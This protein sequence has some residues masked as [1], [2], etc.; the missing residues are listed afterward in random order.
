MV[1]LRADGSLLGD[2]YAFATTAS[3]A[4]MMVIA[5]RHRVIPMLPAACMSALLS[6]LVA[7]PFV[8]WVMPVGVDLLNLALFGLVKSAL[9]LALFTIGSRMI[10]AAETALIGAL[11]APL[12][13]VSVFLAFGEVPGKATVAGGGI[14]FLAVFAPS[15]GRHCDA[16]VSRRRGRPGFTVGARKWLLHC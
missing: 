2:L 10:P 16:P 1:S 12:A 3:M 13:P 7:A 6:A 15:V 4:V 9:G 5:R 14:V 8:A 11:D